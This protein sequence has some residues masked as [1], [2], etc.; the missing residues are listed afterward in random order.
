MAIKLEQT[1]HQLQYVIAS[2]LRSR[3]IFFFETDVMS[4]LQYFPIKDK[5]RFAFIKHH[6]KMGYVKGQSDLVLVLKDRIVF[7]ELKKKEG[8]QSKEQKE[9]ERKVKELGFEYYVWRSLDDA[10]N[11]K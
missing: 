5:R 2:Y 1:E 4:G 9:F 6:T 10:K 8:K 11:F 3:N 7:I